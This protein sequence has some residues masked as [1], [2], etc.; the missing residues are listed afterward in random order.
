M[1]VMRRRISIVERE[2]CAV[3]QLCHVHQ[4]SMEQR[5]VWGVSSCDEQLNAHLHSIIRDRSTLAITSVGRLV[6]SV[7]LLGYMWVESCPNLDEEK[8]LL[9][10]LPQHNP[11]GDAPA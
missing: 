4:P 1:H 11:P 9:M 6:D 8:I 5:G 2:Q 7:T 10:T 3:K